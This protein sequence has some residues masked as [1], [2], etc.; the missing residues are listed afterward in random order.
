MAGYFESP[1]SRVGL[2][3]SSHKRRCQQSK[4]KTPEGRLTK[5][6]TTKRESQEENYN[7]S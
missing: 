5:T 3:L 6:Q 2:A 4:G 1:L 7:Y